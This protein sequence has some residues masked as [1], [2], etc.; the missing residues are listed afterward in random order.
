MIQLYPL[1][2]YPE[3]T[4]TG[5]VSVAFSSPVLPALGRAL[6]QLWEHGVEGRSDGVG[7]CWLWQRCAMLT[8]LAMCLRDGAASRCKKSRLLCSKPRQPGVMECMLYRRRWVL[9]EA[10]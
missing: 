8:V 10:T 2:I 7:W 3:L 5:T 4:R 1:Q 6:S 9:G